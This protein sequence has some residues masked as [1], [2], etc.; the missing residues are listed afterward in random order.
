MKK[1]YFDILVNSFIV[2]TFM[3]FAYNISFKY[4]DRGLFEMVGPFGF[5]KIFD[6]YSLKAVNLQTGFI[7][8]YAFVIIL[9]LIMFLTLF[10]FDS[11]YE[12]IIFFLCLIY[13][14]ILNIFNLK[15]EN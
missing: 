7:Y 11:Y 15:N 5:S 14:P 1:W 8:H 3:K 13:L 12:Y 4:L 2:P 10:L 9:G 6:K